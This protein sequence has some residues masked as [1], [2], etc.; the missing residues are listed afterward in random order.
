MMRVVSAAAVLIIRH[1]KLNERREREKVLE[2]IIVDL[3]SV[4]VTFNIALVRSGNR[5][6]QQNT[7]TQPDCNQSHG[8]GLVCFLS[9]RAVIR[10]SIKKLPRKKRI[11][12]QLDSY[13]KKQIVK[14]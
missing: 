6:H 7:G 14:F 2:Q 3:F 8:Y 10:Q 5:Y 4:C 12:E 13:T 1:E 11:S 9:F